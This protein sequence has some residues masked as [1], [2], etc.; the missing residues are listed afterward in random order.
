[1]KIKI[2]VLLI[3]LSGFGQSK[4]LFEVIKTDI[5]TSGL[6]EKIDTSLTNSNFYEDDKYIVN[7]T[8]NGEWGG[9]IVFKNKFTK[10]EF[11]CGSTCAVKI[12][13]F[14]GRY[15]VTNTLNHMSGR[16]E[17]LEIANPELLKK[18]YD[19]KKK[20]QTGKVDESQVRKGARVLLDKHSFS[21]LYT[22]IYNAKIYHI[23]SDFRKTYI[24]EIE[25]NDF[26]IVRKIMDVAVWDHQTEIKKTKNN[27]DLV[28]FHSSNYKTK[29]YFEVKDNKVTI[30]N[31]K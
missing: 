10:A 19:G 12:T 23:I 6:S 3:S 16:T 8:C 4:N 7:R 14:K 20:I 30:F 5:T 26:K 9:T 25:N 24:A 31:L 15:I 22:F 28:F 29:G 11:I 2:L 13:K 27:T 1:L 17:I 21:T 18:T